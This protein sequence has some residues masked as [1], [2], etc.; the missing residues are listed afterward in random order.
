MGNFKL[1]DRL[2]QL[3][4]KNILSF[5]SDGQKRIMDIDA[6][7]TSVRIHTPLETQE[8]GEDNLAITKRFMLSKIFPT[9]RVNTAIDYT[10]LLGDV[11]AVDTFLGDITIT[12]PP[13]ADNIRGE[14]NICKESDSTNNV[15][16][17]GDNGELINGLESGSLTA[18][19]DNITLISF[20]SYWVIK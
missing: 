11:I 1:Y 20:G 10:A 17:V 15:I 6:R 4:L 16:I 18:Q 8:S 7:D 19:W 14:I 9:A 12:L 3:R 5:T 13:A 2:K